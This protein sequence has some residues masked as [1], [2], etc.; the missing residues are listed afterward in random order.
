[1][2]VLK[3]AFK[4]SLYLSYFLQTRKKCMLPLCS[5]LAIAM[6]LDAQGSKIQNVY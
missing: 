3:I 6:F 4:C 2:N 1:M 5:M